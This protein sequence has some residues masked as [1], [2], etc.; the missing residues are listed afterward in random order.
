MVF[1]SDRTEYNSDLKKG[2]LF[3]CVKLFSKEDKLIIGWAKIWQYI[4]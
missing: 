2:L 1:K 4:I 3:F